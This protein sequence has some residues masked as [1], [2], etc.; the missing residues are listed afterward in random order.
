MRKEPSDIIRLF[1]KLA[2]TDATVHAVLEMHRHGNWPIL[3]CCHFLINQLA[4]EKASYVQIAMDA[5]NAKPSAIVIPAPK[6]DSDDSQS[7]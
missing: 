1:E 3:D 7:R 4:L 2:E 5:L 6:E